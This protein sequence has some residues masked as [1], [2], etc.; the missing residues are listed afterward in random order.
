[1]RSEL[2][3]KRSARKSATWRDHDLG[4]WEKADY[5]G[6]P[7]ATCKRCGMKIYVDANPPANGIDIWGEAIALDC[8]ESR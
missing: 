2:S 1:M 3:L 6:S 7:V 8:E 5:W 4:K